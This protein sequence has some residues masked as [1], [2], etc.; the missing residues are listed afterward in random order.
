M[1]TYFKFKLIVE[2]VGLCLA[3]GTLIILGVI[4]AISKLK[5]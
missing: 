4:K 3:G 2:I 1:E 5:E